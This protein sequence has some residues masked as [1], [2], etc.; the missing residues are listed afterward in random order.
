MISLV[1]VFFYFRLSQGASKLST[2]CKITKPKTEET[3]GKKGKKRQRGRCLA[4]RVRL[5]TSVRSFPL[6][7]DAAVGQGAET[8]LHQP[9]LPSLWRP[10][11]E[12]N[13]TRSGLFTQIFVP[14]NRAVKTI[15]LTQGWG[16]GLASSWRSESSAFATG[17][18]QRMRQ[19]MGCGHPWYLA[20]WGPPLLSAGCGGKGDF[21]PE[22]GG[23]PYGRDQRCCWVHGSALFPS[24]AVN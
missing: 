7:S 6:R 15:S 22:L 9:T 11:S 2:R 18:N 17:T 23:A 4:A 5:E 10:Y 19:S 13:L 24:T 1:T 20:I 21:F 14:Q 16:H 3:E 8:P 12:T